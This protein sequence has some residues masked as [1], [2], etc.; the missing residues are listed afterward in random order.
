[1]SKVLILGCG[2]AGLM[3]AAAAEASGL[4]PIIA[5]KKR[6][7]EMYGA[8]YLHRPI[9]GFSPDMG[10]DVKY[11]LEGT[12]EEYSRKVYGD[13]RI[14][15]SPEDLDEDHEGWDIRVTYDNLW[16]KY[17]DAIEDTP[18]SS[19]SEVHEFVWSVVSN[20]RSGTMHVV[21]TIPARTLCVNPAHVFPFQTVWAI[22]DAPER[23]S[24]CPIQVAQMN[25]VICSGSSDVSW[26]RTAN[27]LGY[28]TAEWPVKKRPPIE[29]ISE[30]IKPIGTTCDCLPIAHRMGR[31][32]AWT[33]GVLS[34]ESYYGTLA[35]LAPDAATRDEALLAGGLAR[36]D[37]RA[38]EG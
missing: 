31:Y 14:S 21:S 17:V 6:K 13:E 4:E 34:H 23:G 22:G 19:A 30:V 10:F 37:V 18:F 32:G 35:G 25:E 20:Y 1:M 11:R 8:Q 24:F 16:R 12:A 15:V 29:G 27:I 38:E 5:S 33:K 28:R 7:S 36:E 26:Y 9:P 3:A 2:P